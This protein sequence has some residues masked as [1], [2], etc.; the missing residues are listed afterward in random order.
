MPR[1]KII[2]NDTLVLRL[3]ATLKK[4]FTTKAERHGRP[5][6]VLRELMTAFVEDRYVIH[7]SPD[8]KPQESLYVPRSED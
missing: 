1:K 5:T 4:R 2:K 6:D 3:T 8:V 7:P